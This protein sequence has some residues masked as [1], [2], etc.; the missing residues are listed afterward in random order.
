MLGI[1]PDDVCWLGRQT[2]P[3]ALGL[4][5]SLIF[6]L[7]AGGRAV[8]DPNPPNPARAGSGWSRHR[9]TLFFAPPGFCAAMVDAGLPGDALSSVRCTVTAGESLLR[10][11]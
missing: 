11:R 5:N 6:P 2:V 1:G 10:R 3:A 7:P 9:P 4:G 8:I